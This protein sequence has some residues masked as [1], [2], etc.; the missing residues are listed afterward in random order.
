MW[1]FSSGAAESWDVPTKGWHED[2]RGVKLRVMETTATAGDVIIC[3]PFLFHAKS[4]NNKQ[5]PRF[6]C[7]KT[8]PL[9]ERMNL[10]RNNIAD[11][12][13]LERSIADAL[14]KSSHALKNEEDVNDT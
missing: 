14:N 11:S 10:S 3:Q 4:Q 5:V 13:P 6:M 1:H 9:R 7:N 12:S 8:M 2:D